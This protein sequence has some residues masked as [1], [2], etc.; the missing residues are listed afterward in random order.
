MP[1]IDLSEIKIHYTVKGS[2][3]PLVILPDN[4]LTG[5][6]GDP[7]LPG[8]AAEYARLS[9]LIPDCSLYLSSKANHPY[10]ERPFLLSEGQRLVPVQYQSGRSIDPE[11]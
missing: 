8:L 10:V 6:L 9:S 2:G 5:H 11:K 7:V 1:Y 4:L 3:Y